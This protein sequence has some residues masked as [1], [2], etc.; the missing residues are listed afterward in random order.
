MFHIVMA[1]RITSAIQR[2][3]V[4]NE[5]PGIVTG[6]I[7]L[8][9]RERPI[10]LEL[11]GNCAN[12]LVGRR[13]SFC[14]PTPAPQH[15]LNHLAR[16]QQGRVKEMT[17]SRKSKIPTVT[18]E[19]AVTR[20]Q[21]QESVP[22]QLANGLFLEWFSD[23]DGRVVLESSC[24]E[25]TVSEPYWSPPSTQTTD[26]T[27]KTPRDGEQPFSDTGED[28]FDD[29]EILDEFQ[30]EQEL[31]EADK[32]VD[33]YQDAL[34]KIQ[35]ENDQPQ[36]FEKVIGRN[37]AD[38]EHDNL[39][40]GEPSSWITLSGESPEGE[41]GEEKFSH[42]YLT[43]RAA[44]FAIS[45][46]ASAAKFSVL[47]RI[48]E[49]GEEEEN[50]IRVMIS[51]SIELGTKLAAALDGIANGV[52]PEPGFVIAMLKRSLLPLNRGIASCQEAIETHR[53]RPSVYS[54]LKEA[55]EE[56]FDMRTEV[57]DFMGELRAE[58]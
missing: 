19:E 15:G 6:Q 42:H 48:K 49:N 3:E 40:D 50:P 43:S 25:L 12:D 7:W 20:I 2:G 32:R 8:E 57:I 36:P 34:E 1:F 28:D 39:T 53:P 30:W 35:D 54:W 21:N 27:G 9:G 55:N 29:D 22:S 44:E 33:A 46:E 17:A 18:E 14:N 38:P 16:L 11:R 58:L 4:T 37:P 26:P 24:C 52:E 47:P 5:I 45:L 51:S 56:F 41:T 23:T 31:R 13:L 10:S